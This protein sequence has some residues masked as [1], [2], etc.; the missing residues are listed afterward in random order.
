MWHSGKL[1]LRLFPEAYLE[2]PAQRGLT[3]SGYRSYPS[4]QSNQSDQSDNLGRKTVPL[5]GKLPVK[6]CKNGA[7]RRKSILSRAL[8]HHV[9]PTDP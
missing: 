1:P 9:L 8:S 3:P 2:F 5:S 7:R 4:N 6:N